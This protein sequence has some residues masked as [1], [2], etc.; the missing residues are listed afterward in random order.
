MTRWVSGKD[1]GG[2]D[3]DNELEAARVEEKR[4]VRSPSQ[5]SRQKTMKA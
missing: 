4:Q 2:C 1:P 5:E 3:E